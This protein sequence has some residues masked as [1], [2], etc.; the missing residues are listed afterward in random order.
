MN[1]AKDILEARL[2]GSVTAHPPALAYSSEGNEP[3][4]FDQAGAVS[5]RGEVML[6][7]KDRIVLPEG[8]GIGLNG[9]PKTTQL[10]V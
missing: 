2:D 8:I 7:A 4:V 5:A 9:E 3:L 6:V 1:R 10:P